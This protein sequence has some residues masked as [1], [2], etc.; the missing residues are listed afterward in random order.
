MLART[1]REHAT[2]AHAALLALQKAL[3]RL[4]ERAPR[5]SRR[6]DSSR[7]I[8][9]GSPL[10]FR[11]LRHLLRGPL[12]PV[13]GEHGGRPVRGRGVGPAHLSPGHRARH[14][15][16]PRPV[17]LSLGYRGRGRTLCHPVDARAGGD[18]PVPL[19][20]RLRLRGGACRLDG[21][22]RDRAGGPCIPHRLQPA[23]VRR[24]SPRLAATA[25]V[26]TSLHALQSG[27]GRH[28]AAHRVLPACSAI[29]GC[30]TRS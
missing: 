26:L 10:L 22:R 11:L 20:R 17:A 27:R 5:G 29:L 6:S 7:A 21:V 25:D 1:T 18:R 23:P 9:P 16:G 28:R 30:A 19:P 12:C 2:D 15:G 14:P 8:L 13:S 4:D 24:V 3:G